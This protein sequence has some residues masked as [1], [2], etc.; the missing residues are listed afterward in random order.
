MTEIIISSQDKLFCQD[1]ARDQIE[2]AIDIASWPDDNHQQQVSGD[3]II[4][5]TRFIDMKLLARGVQPQNQPGI[6]VDYRP[7]TPEMDA[8]EE[9]FGLRFVLR[10]VADGWRMTS[11]EQV[12]CDG[13]MP[14]HCEIDLSPEA[15]ADTAQARA[16]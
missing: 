2:H 8:D 1:I 6:V 5:M 12:Q 16:A 15:L 14:M 4:V 13:G 9:C 7:A 11:V 10:R 3:S